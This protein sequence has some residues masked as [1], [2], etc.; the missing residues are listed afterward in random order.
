M[1]GGSNRR[2]LRKLHNEGLHSFSLF[3]EYYQ[4]N[5]DE[6]G[7]GCNTHRSEGKFNERCFGQKSRREVAALVT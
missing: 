3:T 7:R 1:E 6:V 2:D 4:I 5:V